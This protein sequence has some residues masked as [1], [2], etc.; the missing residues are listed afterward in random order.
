MVQSMINVKEA[1]TLNMG[2]TVQRR[3]ELKVSRHEHSARTYLSRLFFVP[4]ESQ[5]SAVVD[6]C[7]LSPFLPRIN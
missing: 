6:N 7:R 5:M 2:H 3:V 4:L 1:G